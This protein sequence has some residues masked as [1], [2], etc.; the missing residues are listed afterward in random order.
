MGAGASIAGAIFGGI[1]DLFKL[2]MGAKQF[3][4][5]KDLQKQL[6]GKRPTMTTPESFMEKENWVRNAMIDNKMAGQTQMEQQAQANTSN[7]L[8]NIQDTAGSGV[9]ALIASL[10]ANNNQNKILNNIAMSAAQQQ[11]R[12]RQALYGMLGEKANMQ[13]QQWQFNVLQPYMEKAQ[14][15]QA[16]KQ[17]GAQNIS[18]GISGLGNI[19]SSF[20]T[21]N[22]F[23]SNNKQGA[24]DEFI[25]FLNSLFTKKTAQQQVP[26][27]QINTGT[28]ANNINYDML[29]ILTQ[30]GIN[31][32]TELNTNTDISY[33]WKW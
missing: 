22:I 25:S 19:A 23:G 30:S 17:A 16:L 21:S 1:G 12:D 31:P 2:G 32:N 11:E 20:G 9:Q 26:P 5:G 4:D 27:P 6:E 29:N 7:Q 18:T 28:N 3:K 24:N 10:V 8:R 14:Q 13:Q 33:N 15:A